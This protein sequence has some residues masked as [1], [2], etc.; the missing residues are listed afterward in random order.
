MRWWLL[1]VVLH[2]CV[3]SDD[4]SASDKDAAADG[5]SDGDTD[6]GADTEDTDEV[7]GLGEGSVAFLH[8]DLPDAGDTI[9]LAGV[10]VDDLGG[11]GNVAECTFLSAS[12][13]WQG[14][15]AVGEVI[16]VAQLV[17]D[18]ENADYYDVG[19]SILLGS[20]EAHR[21]VSATIGW[22]FYR[23]DPET[24]FDSGDSVGLELSGA[25]GDYQGSDD[26][27]LPER[28]DL[29]ITNPSDRSHQII[30]RDGAPASI[31]WTPG[32]ADAMTIAVQGQVVNRLIGIEDNGAVSLDPADFGFATLPEGLE[33]ELSRW[34]Q[35]ESMAG[36]NP[37]HLTGR[38]AAVMRGVYVPESDRVLLVP[39]E[40]C[41]DASVGVDVPPGLYEGDMNPFEDNHTALDEGCTGAAPGG[42]GP[43]GVLPVTLQ[44]GQSL[45]VKYRVFREDAEI[46]LLAGGCS[47]S[48]E[49]VADVVGVDSQELLYWENTSGEATRVFV[50][51]DGDAWTGWFYLELAISG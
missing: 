2:G 46:Y 29:T 36:A 14:L 28:L 19:D 3:A 8:R 48:C 27:V 12:D 26:L 6:V 13:C 43:E 39:Y 50:V 42:N 7:N 4:G 17:F 9:D 34:T 24:E 1:I 35:G 11:M 21:F 45:T 20:L 5:D 23:S 15:P 49:A 40:S 10:F 32:N 41:N 22:T 47:Q 44:D 31:Q 37:V 25:F 18:S 30:L 38:S 16:N 33:L 51:L